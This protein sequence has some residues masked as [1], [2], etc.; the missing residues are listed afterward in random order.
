VGGSFSL[1]NGASVNEFSTD[2]TMAGNSD[3]AVPTEK[4]VKKY[5][6]DNILLSDTFLELTDT[7]ST[8]TAAG[9]IYVV[10]SAAVAESAVILAEG[11]NTFSLTK[12]TASLDIAAGAAL[13]V[14]ANLTVEATSA[15]N[16][17]V[18]SDG[19]P[20]FAALGVTTINKVTI[21]A[22]ATGSTLTILDGKVFTVNHTMTLAGTDG[23][24]YTMPAASDTMAALGTAQTF[25]KGQAITIANTINQVGLTV[26]Q[27]DT[28]NNNNAL[29]I[30]NTG[31]GMGLVIDQQSVGYAI[32]ATWKGAATNGTYGYRFRNSGAAGFTGDGAMMLIHLINGS[33]TGRAVYIQHSGTNTGNVFES[34]HGGAGSG[35]AGV[36]TNQGT[37]R[38]LFVDDNGPGSSASLYVDRDGNSSSRIWGIKIDSDN[39]GAGGV[40]GLDLSGFSAAEP[41]INL[42]VD[43]GGVG[44]AY[45]RMAVFVTG[46]GVKYI[47]LSEAA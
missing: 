16:Q 15:I 34:R 24:T 21:T 11:A 10:G 2:G 7:P 5:V 29:S 38:A 28:T 14:N 43:T 27:N 46:I 31:T 42:P 36:F 22:P 32:D 37:G 40:G 23:R 39:A 4:A 44:A 26:T 33:D 8:Y 30:V 45:G 35:D 17:D 1:L 9:A 41:V 12:G 6:D 3:T 20:T 25:S 47:L 18:T 13:D 19:N